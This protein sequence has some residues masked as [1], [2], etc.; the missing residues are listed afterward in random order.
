MSGSLVPIGTSYEDGA[1]RPSR[2]VGGRDMQKGN[3]RC[4][5]ETICVGTCQDLE[6][7]PVRHSFANRGKA[8]NPGSVKTR[9]ISVSILSTRIVSKKNQACIRGINPVYRYKLL[10]LCF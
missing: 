1:L 3:C 8:E 2:E 7:L 9:N 5:Y 4:R 6:L 10:P